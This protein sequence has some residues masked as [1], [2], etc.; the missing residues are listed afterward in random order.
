MNRIILAIAFLQ[1]SFLIAQITTLP[2]STTTSNQVTTTNLPMITSNTMFSI[3]ANSNKTLNFST[4]GSHNVG[5]GTYG[6]LESVLIQNAST[7]PSFNNNEGK[8]HIWHVSTPSITQ[9]GPNS[10]KTGG[11]Q[12][13]LDQKAIYS[14]NSPPADFYSRLQFRSTGVANI[15]NTRYLQSGNIWEIKAKSY[16]YAYPFTAN[17][18]GYQDEDLIIRHSVGGSAVTITGNTNTKHHGFTKLGDQINTPNV[19]MVFLTGT[20]AN[21]AF[22][23]IPHGVTNPLKIIS[24]SVLVENNPINMIPPSYFINAGLHY[25][26]D[27]NGSNIV[28]TPAASSLVNLNGKLAKILVT[29]TE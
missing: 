9:T 15:G 11:P 10:P 16:V 21:A 3:G 25:D 12:L 13:L 18:P 1:S 20:I 22:T 28:L 23:L 29:Y 4:G 27:I 8:L 19:K 24:I 5:I 14:P 17:N 6:T 2:T 7:T 26:Y